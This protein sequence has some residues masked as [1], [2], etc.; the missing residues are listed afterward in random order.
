M[1]AVAVVRT[2]DLFA[3]VMFTGIYSL[4]S[5][6][7]FVIFDAVDVAF[8]EAAIGA[9]ISTLLM[10]STLTLTGR[11]AKKSKQKPFLA[12]AIV[13]VTGALLIYGTLDMPPIGSAMAPIHQHVTP[14]YL[15]DSM[16]E[17]AVPNVVTSI[18]ASYR[19]YDTLGEVFVIFTAGIGVLA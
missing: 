13:S 7:F 16:Q 12:L 4:L 6:S 1:T 17:I 18:L 14:R 9:G 5:A 8:T 10:L 3:V 11:Y 19:G 2:R 15:N